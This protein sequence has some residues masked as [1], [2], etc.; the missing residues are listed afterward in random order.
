TTKRDLGWL[1]LAEGDLAA[2]PIGVRTLGRTVRAVS[3]D[4]AE[5]DAFVRIRLSYEGAACRLPD[6]AWPWY[7][8]AELLAWAGFAERAAEHLAA[9]ERR[10]MC[11]RDAQRH[12]TTLARGLVAVGLGPGPH[13]LATAARPY[14]AEPFGLPN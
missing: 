7:R 12:G 6:V 13:G 10:G 5:E 1:A 11:T 3:A 2:G 14:P 9:A 4:Q 8:L